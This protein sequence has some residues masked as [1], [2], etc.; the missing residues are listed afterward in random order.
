MNTQH[1]I[2]NLTHKPYKGTDERLKPRTTI[3]NGNKPK[4]HINEIIIE[5]EN[6]ITQRKTKW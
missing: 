6:A 3:R 4:R 5:R 2:I 1:K